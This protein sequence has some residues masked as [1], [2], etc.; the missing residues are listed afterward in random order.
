MRSTILFCTITFFAAG[1][2]GQH[3]DFETELPLLAEQPASALQ[4]YL[5]EIQQVQLPAGDAVVAKLRGQLDDQ[6]LKLIAAGHMAP[7]RV[8]PGETESY[9]Y[10]TDPFELIL[11]FSWARPYMSDAVAAKAAEYLAKEVA[12]YPVGPV[13]LLPYD[14]GKFREAYELPADQR[15]F[16]YRRWVWRSVNTRPRMMAFYAMWAYAEAFK[17]WATVEQQYPQLVLLFDEQYNAKTNLLE[18]AVGLAAFAR[19][20]TYMGDTERAARANSGA[21]ELLGKQT[22]VAEMN[23]LAGVR[24]DANTKNQSGRAMV[25]PLIY[26]LVNVAPESARFLADRHKADIQ[27]DVDRAMSRS[28]LWYVPLPPQG[29]QLF[30]EG[31]SMA[32]DIRP[33]IMLGRAM[34]LDDSVQNLVRDLDIPAIPVGDLFYMQTLTAIIERAGNRT[35]VAYQPPKRAAAFGPAD[36]Q[37]IDELRSYLASLKTATWKISPSFP[38]PKKENFDKPLDPEKGAVPGSAAANTIG[39]RDL[40]TDEYAGDLKSIFPDDPKEVLAYAWTRVYSPKRVDACVLLRNDD[41]F[42]AWVNG[43]EILRNGPGLGWMAGEHR[44]P[45]TLEQGWNPVLLKLDQVGGAWTFTAKFVSAG[46]APLEGLKVSAE[47]PR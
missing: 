38:D 36:R 32:P 7:W 13:A 11:T 19:I 18:E 29:D 2:W 16:R 1:A 30:G 37:R 28:P 17:Q 12:D 40:K 44:A 39:W 22:S 14:Q 47:A 41:G 31:C 33:N 6:V 4:K 25:R 5:T 9:F 23:T 21:L 46:G 15:T 27:R 45:V 24:Y 43:K 10:F 8:Q 3:R 42:A 35:F 26:P 34:V 20:A